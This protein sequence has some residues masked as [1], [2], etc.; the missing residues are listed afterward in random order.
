MKR[1]FPVLY[2]MVSVW[3]VTPLVGFSTIFYAMG[4]IRH[5][6]SEVYPVGLAALGVTAALS[7]ICFTMAPTN[8][9]YSTERYAGEKFLHSSLLL[10]QS[11]LVVYIRDAVLA[12]AW[13]QAHTTIAGNI[14]GLAAAAFSFVAAAAAWTWHH[15]FTDL[16]AV[17]WKNWERRISE[18][19]KAANEKKSR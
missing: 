18:L 3:I 1:E 7:G 16:N 2:E 6:A 13:M 19:N 4:A 17:L 5:P 11:L 9:Q 14:A 12:S 15:G 8:G 10:I